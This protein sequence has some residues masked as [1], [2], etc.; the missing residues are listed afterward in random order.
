[1][2]SGIYVE[3][4]I[5]SWKI[6][7][8]ER[9]E[10]IEFF[11]PYA[12]HLDVVI[13]EE[14]DLYHNHFDIPIDCMIARAEETSYTWENVVHYYLFLQGNRLI[15]M[16]NDFEMEQEAVIKSCLA[17]DE[18]IHKLNQYI[19]ITGDNS[20]KHNLLSSVS[21]FLNMETVFDNRR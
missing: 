12:D 7:L 21:I 15:Y 18:C 16:Y 10:K 11:F 20:D 1:M 19:P 9:T 17:T 3:F 8:G 6:Y 2:L 4:D 5:F 13:C 14:S